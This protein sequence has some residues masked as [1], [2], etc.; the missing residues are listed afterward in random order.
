MRKDERMFERSLLVGDAHLA[1]KDIAIIVSR[2]DTT[3]SACREDRCRSLG[4]LC[5]ISSQVHA[6]RTTLFRGRRQSP[7]PANMLYP[8]RNGCREVL[9]LG[10]SASRRP[11]RGKSCEARWRHEALHD[12][13]GLGP[14]AAKGR[15]VVE[16][17]SMES[18]AGAGRRVRQT[19]S[20]EHT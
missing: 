6:S 9:P 12:H 8:Y 14:L 20:A 3:N 16:E 17:L 2:F 13:L 18:I 11:R 5:N 19:S 10:A 4:P 15:V 1:E 7:R